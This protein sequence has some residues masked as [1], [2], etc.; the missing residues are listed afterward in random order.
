MNTVNMSYI[1]MILK[2]TSPEAVPVSFKLGRRKI[3]GIP[4]EFSPKVS[5]EF[6]DSNIQKITVEG[7]NRSGLTIRAD[8]TEYRDFPVTEWRVTIT[9]N[10]KKDTPIISELRIGGE[11]ACG[12]ST[13]K[14]GNG[15]TCK[16]DGYSFFEKEIDEKISLTPFSGT[17]CQG[18]FPYMTLR[19]EGFELR[20]AI[21]FPS[22]W[23]AEIAP[24]ERGISFLCGQD[25]C[26]T[27]L[28][29]G[30]SFTS[31]RLTLMAYGAGSEYRG[32]NIWRRFYF[33]HILPK[34]NGA[35][36]PPKLCLHYFRA[37]GKPE[38]TGATEENQLHALSEYL[39]K[40][41]KPDV[42]WIDA[43]W[44]PC[45]YNWPRIGTWKVDEARFPRGLAPIGEA[46]KE[47]DIDFL[48]WFEPE[49]VR[50]GEEIDREHPE[51]L[52]SVGESENKLFDLGNPEAREW[53]TDRVD[54]IIKASG[55]KIYRQDFNFDPLP[56]WK[57]NEAPDRIG[58]LEN[59][60]AMGYLAYWDELVLRNPGLIIDSCASG[61]RRNDLE[62]MRRAITLHYT[63]VGYGDHPI[64]QKQ[65]REMF[66]WIPYFRAHNM[67]WFDP[68]TGKYD[69]KEREA[70]EFAYYN[71]FAPSMTDMARYDVDDATA[72]RLRA[73]Q[74]LWRKVAE[75]ELDGDYYPITECR[76]STEDWYAMQFDDSEKR[77]GFVQI[78]R[79]ADAEEDTFLLKFPYVGNAPTYHV[80]DADS[81]TMTDYCPDDLRKG[82]EIKLDKHESKILLYMYS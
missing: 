7:K 12:K 28:S 39:R 26:Y 82:I 25:R 79:N 64:K 17:S 60:H 72:P 14:Y 50:K 56:I 3:C 11:I 75:V 77:H 2:Y 21:G 38:F 62:T 40:D 23:I 43:G 47:N 46:C 48:L 1:P 45:D 33:A 41:M 35:K 69:G 54:S 15:D 19:G 57:E 37:E 59:R 32:I 74:E 16:R 5:R 58:F 30:E 44:Y 52:L 73:L 80:Y 71:A 36:M 49:R 67:N 13:L 53:I 9:N 61:G 24:T 63:D 68:E 6:V 22:K 31:P 42:W 65:H 76:G 10:G 34:D 51:W 55:V 8:Y 66:E 20:A 78:V 18:A 81:G 29:A 4:E 27:R 70:D